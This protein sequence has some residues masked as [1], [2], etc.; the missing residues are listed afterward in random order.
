MKNNVDKIVLELALYI[1]KSLFEDNK[2]SYKSY[3][4]TE[5]NILKQLIKSRWQNGFI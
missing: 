3:K 1:N 5:E 4:Y 2:I